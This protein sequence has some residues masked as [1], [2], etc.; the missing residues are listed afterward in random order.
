M[1]QMMDVLWIKAARMMFARSFSQNLMSLQHAR[2]WVQKRGVSSVTC[3]TR[4]SHRV[5]PWQD[6]KGPISMTSPFSVTCL[7]AFSESSNLTVHKRVHSG[8][9]PYQC[10]VCQ[11]AFSLL[12]H[13]TS[14]KR[15][16]S[17]DRPFQCDLCPKAFSRFQ[18]LT[19]HKLTHSGDKPYQCDVCH[20]AFSNLSS[21]RSHKKAVHTVNEGN[22]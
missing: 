4:L 22:A 5:V 18:Y 21:L 10:D 9:K 8:D 17:G 3:V 7:K 20:K 2:K 19:V 14:H 12:H 16:H 6:T 13:L 1:Y 15:V 11:R